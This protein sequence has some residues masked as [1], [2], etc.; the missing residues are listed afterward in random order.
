VNQAFQRRYFMLTPTGKLLW[1]APS[2]VSADHT[3]VG[4][5]QGWLQV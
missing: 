1:F 2:Q 5:A 4:D 3:T